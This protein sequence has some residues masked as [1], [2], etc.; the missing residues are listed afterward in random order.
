MER[1][2]VISMH[3]DANTNVLEH[4]D[5]FGA[6]DLGDREPARL[7]DLDNA[8]RLLGRITTREVEKRIAAGDLESVKLGRRRLVVLES[9]DAFVTRLREAAKS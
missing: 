9:L 2:T 8:A 1:R 5:A 6:V 4:G 3:G 7:I